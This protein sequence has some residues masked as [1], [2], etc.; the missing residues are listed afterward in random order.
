VVDNWIVKRSGTITVEGDLRF[1][2]TGDAL[3]IRFVASSHDRAA[4]PNTLRQM[5]DSFAELMAHLSECQECD[6]RDFLR[7]IARGAVA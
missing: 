5:Q 2:E 7:E 1:C 3:A 4:A 6:A